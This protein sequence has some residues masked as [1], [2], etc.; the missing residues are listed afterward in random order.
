MIT[1]EVAKCIDPSAFGFELERKDGGTIEVT[2]VDEEGSKK[3]PEVR[4]VIV[5]CETMII[6][7]SIL[8]TINTRLKELKEAG[9]GFEYPGTVEYKK[10]CQCAK[11]AKSILSESF[12]F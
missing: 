10:K 12:K 9:R 6:R 11:S 3:Q 5:Q 4:S 7:D 2:P 1:R 8:K